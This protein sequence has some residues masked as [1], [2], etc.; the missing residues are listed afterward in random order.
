MRRLPVWIDI[1]IVGTVSVLFLLGLIDWLD[2]VHLNTTNGMWKSVTVDSWKANFRAAPLDPSNYLYYPEMSL[3][4]RLLD[5]VGIRT[6]QTWR[7]LAL[8]NACFAAVGVG[9]VYWMVRRLT[10][11]R[12]IA[13]V[14]A[15]VQIGSAFFLTLSLSNEDILP[16]FTPVLA[17]MTLAAVWFAQPTPGQVATVAVVF[18][19]GWLGEWRLIFPVLPAFLLALAVS[20]GTLAR[21]G[22]LILLFLATTVGLAGLVAL[23]WEGHPGAVGL[24][25][26]L[27]TGKGV[28]SGWSGF[29]L[30]KLGLL[31]GGM[32]EYWLDG[33]NLPVARLF[34]P[35]GAEWGTA[36][37]FEML[38]LVLA[39]VFFWRRRRDPRMRVV[40]AVFLGTLAAGTVMNAYSQ[41]SDPQMQINVMG[42]M[43][44]AAALLL[45]AAAPSRRLVMI[46][47]IV[48][49]LPLAY[50]V[51]AASVERGHDSKMEAALQQ[52]EKL[53]DPART[54]YVYSGWEYMVTWQFLVWQ[55]RWEGVCDLGPSPQPGD[56]FKWI[57]LFSP[58]VHHPEF[59]KDEFIRAVETE[60]NCAFDKGYRVIAGPVWAKSADQ[61][62]DWMT[63][64]NARDQALALH[65][66]LHKD[67]HGTP[68]G[69]PNVDNGDYWE[70]TRP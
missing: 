36:F 38:L 60:L 65:A 49:L 67:Y 29:S 54:V 20:R 1:V 18:T 23:F 61:L 34:T 44:V 62:A 43:T 15:L 68:I 55:H 27:W 9:F 48:A 58:M 35:L 26:L 47:A 30:E 41:P 3:L 8:I 45:A 5:L 32:G 40:A 25:D 39:L 37:A 24:P 69:G 59:T 14:A 52:L 2:N 42:W 63:A 46:A 6:G 50:N 51:K 17:A 57:S 66:A 11:R 56:R 10:G 64:L 31:V 53:S 12:D 13:A 70:I 16:S 21:R 19:F 28:G 7:Q 4:S 22:G 33:S